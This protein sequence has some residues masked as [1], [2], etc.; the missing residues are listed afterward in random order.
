[1]AKGVYVS[2]PWEF[3]MYQPAPNSPLQNGLPSQRPIIIVKLNSARSHKT[4]GNSAVS[5]VRDESLS[6]PRRS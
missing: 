4:P 3:S 1:M 5:R 2:K 6:T